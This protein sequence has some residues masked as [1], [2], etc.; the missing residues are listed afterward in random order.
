[1]FWET[2]TI[3]RSPAQRDPEAIKS[4]NGEYDL[5]Y[6]ITN[7]DSQQVVSC[8]CG[9]HLHFPN[10]TL[11]EWLNH[12]LRSKVETA[13]R[14]RGM[15]FSALNTEQIASPGRLLFFGVTVV[16]FGISFTPVRFRARP[17]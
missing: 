11:L 1:L 4:T 5:E 8:K 14:R 9:F 16:T 3:W 2:P 15:Y 6:F 7:A 17:Q 10:K 12:M 13:K